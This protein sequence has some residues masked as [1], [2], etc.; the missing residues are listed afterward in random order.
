MLVCFSNADGH[1]RREEGRE[2]R[3]DTCPLTCCTVLY[4]QVHLVGIPRCPLHHVAAKQFRSQVTRGATQ[5]WGATQHMALTQVQM[6]TQSLS[7]T[8]TH[9]LSLQNTCCILASHKDF[10]DYSTATVTRPGEQSPECWCLLLAIKSGD[11]I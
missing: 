11:L 10:P 1:G 5:L 6:H 2:V 4:S 3:R 7:H 9:T 8:N